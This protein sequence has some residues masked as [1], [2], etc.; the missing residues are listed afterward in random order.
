MDNQNWLISWGW[1]FP[2]VKPADQ[3]P[4]TSV[5]EYNPTTGQELLSLTLSDGRSNTPPLNTRSYALPFKALAKQAEPLSAAFPDS[6]YTSTFSLGATDAPT[7]VVAFSEPVTDFPADT[8]S[9][10]VQ[11]ATVAG[12]SLHLVAGEAADAYLFTL[13]PTGDGPVTFESPRRRAV[14][15]RRD[16]HPGRN[17]ALG[18]ACA[19]RDRAAAQGLLHG[20]GVQ[21]RRRA[22]RPP[23][24]SA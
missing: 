2:S 9:V 3:R 4:D 8:P 18:R 1:T 13:T 7:V 14:R 21:R 19:L 24:P 10:A 16:L 6:R 17:H 12:V 15:G 11:G 23:L 5:T 20:A 22:R